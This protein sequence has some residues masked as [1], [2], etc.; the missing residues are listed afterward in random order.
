MGGGERQRGKN[1]FTMNI[2]YVPP[3][4]DEDLVCVFYAKARARPIGEENTVEVSMRGI[5]A[6]ISRP[7]I[8]D[9][10]HFKNSRER[11]ENLDFAEYDQRYWNTFT[12]SEVFPE[13]K[14]FP[15]S[16]NRYCMKNN[17]PID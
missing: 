8:V 11:T 5:D 12:T 13:G 16:W 1:R 6:S 15:S 10:L 4:Y 3:I 17:L 2:S 9:V 14:P 7:D